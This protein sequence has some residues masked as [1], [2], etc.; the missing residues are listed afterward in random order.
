M[1]DYQHLGLG[2]GKQSNKVYEVL[3]SEQLLMVLEQIEK[4]Y[5]VKVLYAC[6]SGSIAWGFPS[7]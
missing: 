4:E 2:Y 6:E 1:I 3:L 5:D 7:K